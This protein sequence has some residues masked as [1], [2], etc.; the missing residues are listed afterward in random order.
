LPDNSVEKKHRFKRGKVSLARITA[1]EIL[2]RVETEGAFAAPLLDARSGRL[3]QQDKRLVYELTL[4]VL[5]KK[6]Y[7]DW[8]IK[9]FSTRFPKDQ[10]V[11]TALRLGL[12]QLLFMTGI[13]KYAA[14]N[15]SVL[16]V[17]KYGKKSAKAQVN[18]ILRRAIE[19][20][21][22]LNF[23][24]EVEEIS[25]LE[26]FPRW[27]LERWIEAYSF[28]RAVEIA[29]A[30]NLRQQT[31][32]RVTAKGLR[33]GFTPPP[34]TFSHPEVADSFVAKDVSSLLKPAEEGLIYF[35]EP[36][37][38][39][40]GKLAS[41]FEAE[42]ILDL[43][44]APGGKTTLIAD[45]FSK[46]SEND[47]MRAESNT[48]PENKAEAWV[49]KAKIYAGDYYFQRLKLLKEN[50][51]R[52]DKEPPLLC[53]YDAE[54]G[55]PFKDESFD[56]IIVDAPCSGT[57]TIRSNPELRYRIRPES[58]LELSGKQRKIL[59]NAS[60]LLRKGGH[61]IYSVCSL[62]PEE[63]EDVI[64]QFLIENKEFKLVLPKVPAKYICKERLIRTFP[65]RDKM[66]GFFAA[67]MQRII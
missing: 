58:I 4:G 9:H 14:V 40:V 18:A 3:S 67:I 34:D 19:E 20:E 1:F 39:F 7:L 64:S 28:E 43:C 25:V 21:V 27:L 61:L 65:D 42:N 10:E 55:L 29:K 52:Q 48:E 59:S 37:S 6:I 56:L 32:F 49:R 26:S 47:R 46:S 57:G 22:T 16:L 24:D 41:N 44:A 66:D 11:L 63:G 31:A 30:L 35:Q 51:L 54:K 50:F 8:I 45:I 23:P 5:R 33:K 36:A 62:E 13:T 15:E 53:L 12:Y 60:K 2:F 38:Q 17:E